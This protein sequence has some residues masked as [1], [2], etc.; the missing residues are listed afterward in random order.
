MSQ[1]N[2]DE[3]VTGEAEHDAESHDAEEADHDAARPDALLKRVEA[4]GEEDDVER[5]A[6]E[7][8][9]KLAE[10][11][12]QQGGGKKRSGLEVAASKKLAKVGTKKASKRVQTEVAQAV[13]ADPLLDRTVRFTDWAKKNSSLVQGIVIAAL[14]GAI[15]VGTYTYLAQRKVE[16]ASTI[17]ADAVNDENG[18][19]GDP[20]ADRGDAPKEIR[21]VFRTTADKRES[22]LKKYREVQEK[23]PKTGAAYLARLAEGSILLDKREAD[24]AIAAFTDASRSPLAA[25][26]A[27][28]RGRAIEGLGFAY[29]LKGEYEQ[30]LKTFKELENAVDVKGFKELAMYHQARALEAKGDKDAAKDLLKT[31]HERITRPGESQQF[32]YLREVTEDRLRALDPAALPP[33]SASRGGPQ[34][35]QEQIRKFLEQMKAQ[36]GGANPVQLPEP[37]GGAA[38]PDMP[39]TPGMPMPG[40][41]PMPTMPQMPTMPVVPNPTPQPAPHP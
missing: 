11:R 16:K 10:R 14:V 32:S 3:N 37:M 29:E 27:E 1:D 18:T 28:V 38:G 21:P 40:M 15:G 20:D 2:Q 31:L 30:A 22:A 33:K 24:A 13:E 39:Q 17:L 7:E 4:L 34:M 12:A 26:D 36:K 9:R 41:T 8:E 19:L 6:R 25:N 23:F 35:T 5:L